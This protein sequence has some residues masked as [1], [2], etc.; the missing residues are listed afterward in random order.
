M[1]SFK[2]IIKIFGK[3]MFVFLFFIFLVISFFYFSVSF[4]YGFLF[5]YF[6]DFFFINSSTIFFQSLISTHN[7]IM[8]LLFFVVIIVSWILFFVLK[9]YYWGN[10]VFYRSVFFKFFF[11]IE[12][13]LKNIFSVVYLSFFKYFVCFFYIAIY[14][15]IFFFNNYLQNSLKSTGF[16]SDSNVVSFFVNKSNQKRTWKILFLFIG[17]FCFHRGF[18][19]SSDVFTKKGLFDTPAGV[20]YVKHLKAKQEVEMFVFG[21]TTTRSEA[22]KDTKD[23]PFQ[24]QKFVH[25]FKLELF[26]AIFPTLKCLTILVPSLILLYSSAALK[27][28]DNIQHVTANQ[29]YWN[30]SSTNVFSAKPVNSILFSKLDLGLVYDHFAL[31]N[32]ND[33]WWINAQAALVEINQEDS[34][35]SFFDT[36]SNNVLFFDSAI[37]GTLES[38]FDSFMI[39]DNDLLPF[40]QRVLETDVHLVLACLRSTKLVINAAD[41]LH[42]F[43]ILST[44]VKVDAIVGRINEMTIFI[45]RDGLYFGQ[46]SELCGSGHF[47][48]PIVVEAL[49]PFDFTAYIIDKFWVNFSD[50]TMAPLLPSFYDMDAEILNILD[51]TTNN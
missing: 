18:Y 37:D 39:A 26:W 4:S 8:S 24:V 27:F 22:V 20:D 45:L 12:Y 23:K 15:I 43:V 6:F 36:D 1:K 34:S 9:H 16:F 14:N 21:N 42:S 5:P 19:L 51:K 35:S 29:W 38:N 17:H 7:F 10:F 25:S 49:Q 44:G 46:C 32:D 47:G 11:K 48:M 50:N 28:Y 2:K 31:S 40:Q 33:I 3:T 41:V 30:Y 13:T